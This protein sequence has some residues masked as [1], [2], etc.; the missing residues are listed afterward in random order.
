M[1]DCTVSLDQREVNLIHS[2][3]Q[4]EEEKISVKGLLDITLCSR[5]FRPFEF[6]FCLVEE[7]QG[8]H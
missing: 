4:L 2:A 7:H 6:N 5:F 8:C 3:I 1:E